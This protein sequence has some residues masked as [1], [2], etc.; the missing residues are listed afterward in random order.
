MLRADLDEGDLGEPRVD[1]LFDRRDDLGCVGAAR[2]LLGDGVL[3]DRLDEGL[4]LSTLG[5][6][7]WIF[8]PPSD[9]PNCWCAIV[10]HVASSSPQQTAIWPT[11][12]LPCPPAAPNIWT[13]SAFGSVETM[14]SAVAPARPHDSWPLTAMPSGGGS[15][16]SKSSALSTS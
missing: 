16:R 11:T 4:E 6:S 3:T 7:D 15:G 9:H 2:H 8:Q 12:G 10:R 14:N 1:E 13:N 5:S